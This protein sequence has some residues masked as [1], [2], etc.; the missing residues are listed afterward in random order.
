MVV[1]ARASQLRSGR[2]VGAGPGARQRRRQRRVVQQRGQLVVRQGDEGVVAE[3]PAADQAGEQPGRQGVA[4][5]DGV[6]HVDPWWPA[7]EQ[8]SAGPGGAQR[9]PAVG[10]HH[11]R[12]PLA[13]PADGGL[14]EVGARFEPLE[15]LR[16]DLDHVGGAAQP[17]DPRRGRRPRRRSAR[18]GRWGRRRPAHRPRRAPGGPARRSRPRRAPSSWRWSRCARSG[19]RPASPGPARRSSTASRRRPRCGTSSRPS[20]R[21]GARRRPGSPARARRPSRR[22][23]PRCAGRA[24]GTA[25]RTAPARPGTSRCTVLPSRAAATA[26]LSALPPGN[27]VYCGASPSGRGLVGDEVDHELA[28]D[29]DH[30]DTVAIRR[31]SRP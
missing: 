11:Q 1:I 15:V 2:R 25:R 24:R 8:R 28:A 26:T 27:A 7:A 13:G 3:R 17:V 22:W 9:L 14:V 5:A 29:G 6:D 21:P 30:R 23:R 18:P 4:R 20:R 12:R 31:R 10:H 19:C 16:A